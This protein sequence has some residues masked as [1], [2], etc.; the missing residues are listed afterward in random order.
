MTLD[1]KTSRPLPELVEAGETPDS[2][3]GELTSSFEAEKAAVSDAEQFTQLRN[4]WLGRKNGLLA[5]ANDAWLKGAPRELK[6]QVGKLQNLTKKAIEK[7][8]T[9]A[10]KAAEAAGRKLEALDVTLP[11]PERK[12]GAKHPVRLVLE[13]CFEIFGSLGY[14]VFEGPEIESFFYNFEALNFPPDHPAVDEMGH[15]LHRGQD[16]AAHAYLAVPNP[17]NGDR[18][19]A[20]ALRGARQGLPERRSGRDALADVPSA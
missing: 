8:L 7:S 14:S 5:A 18:E 3:Y 20:A 11:G 6:P 13:E 15:S 2:L 17:G 4:R 10:Q 16:A 1:E 12:L 19:A 9:E